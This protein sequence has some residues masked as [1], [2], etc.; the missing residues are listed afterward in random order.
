MHTRDSPLSQRTENFRFASY[1]GSWDPLFHVNFQSKSFTGRTENFRSV[2]ETLK[3]GINFSP[4]DGQKSY[5]QY[6]IFTKR[7]GKNV[8][9]CSGSQRFRKKAGTSNKSTVER[10]CALACSNEEVE[11]GG[12]E[13]CPWSL[14]CRK[15]CCEEAG[16]RFRS[17]SCR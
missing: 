1:I 17:M 5:W 12:K 10:P 13:M 6:A 11:G 7:R 8:L 16:S 3:N 4:R 9:R 14:E 2:T 15:N